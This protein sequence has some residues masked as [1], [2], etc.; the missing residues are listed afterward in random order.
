MQICSCGQ[1]YEADYYTS[2]L[3]LKPCDSTNGLCPTCVEEKNKELELAEFAEKKRV[4]NE[5]REQWRR[6]CGIPLTYMESRFTTWVS[7]R[8]GNVDKI[9]GICQGYANNY[10][11]LKPQYY[12]SLVL[13]SPRIW[14]I[15]KTHLAC[16]I[17]HRVLDRWQGEN[18]RCPIYF[19]TEQEL[20]SRIK[21]TYN[22][23]YYMGDGSLKQE[24]EE[25][26]IKFITWIPL[27]IIDDVGKEEVENS[28]FVQRMLFRII[29]GR[30]N[31][32]KLPMVITANM[33]VP[34]FV[35][36][37]GGDNEASMDRL[38]ESADGKFWEMNGK[39]F[40]LKK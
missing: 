38:Q 35:R 3:T 25:D 6:S 33:S 23:V 39:D 36:H 22:R 29:N 31:N 1:P 2:L 28:K 16:S 12:K 26:V 14:G 20:L 17:A 10:P 4:N 19:I 5:K 34:E 11:I 27:L 24:T 37:L 8:G 13:T 15:G 18:I 32:A 7:G 30:Y 21:A 9:H 40:R